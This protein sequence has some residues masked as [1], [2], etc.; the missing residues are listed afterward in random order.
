MKDRSSTIDI[1]EHSEAQPSRSFGDVF[2]DLS[3]E[4]NKLVHREL[5]SAKDEL[6]ADAPTTGRASV[7]LGGAAAAAG[8]CLL[9]VSIALAI[10]L[11]EL[12]PMGF[13]FLVVGVAYGIGAAALYRRR[14]SELAPPL[15]PVD[16]NDY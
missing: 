1:R 11:G 15:E 16:G 13:A 6:R 12:M 10:G 9:F 7:L 8:F 4:L 14:Q 2:G 5:Q 3:H